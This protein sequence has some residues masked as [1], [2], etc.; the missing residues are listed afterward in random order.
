MHVKKL[1]WLVNNF[2]HWHHLEYLRCIYISLYLFS[3]WL[4]REFLDQNFQCCCVHTH[5]EGKRD[6]TIMMLPSYK[7]TCPILMSFNDHSIFQLLFSTLLTMHL[8][9]HYPCQFLILLCNCFQ[10]RNLSQWHLLVFSFALILLLCLRI[11]Y[12]ARYMFCL[13]S[14]GLCFCECM[15]AIMKNLHSNL[16][17][18]KCIPIYE[19]C[20]DTW[21]WEAL[22]SIEKNHLYLMMMVAMSRSHCTWHCPLLALS[23]LRLLK[24]VMPILRWKPSCKHFT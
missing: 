12:L 7:N 5:R 22:V 19:A 4:Y 8:P 14:T 24:R 23:P 18:G 21:H 6:T 10:A 3:C 16:I 9:Y 15:R 11:A 13:C 1:E 17:F 2:V 20:F